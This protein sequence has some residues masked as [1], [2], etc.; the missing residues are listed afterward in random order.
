[1]TTVVTGAAGRIGR[2]LVRHLVQQGGSVRGIVRKEEDAALLPKGCECAV[3]DI[4]SDDLEKAFAGATRVVH[5]AAA[6]DSLLGEEKLLSINAGGTRRVLEAC[7]KGVSRVVVASS[8]S[9]YGHTLAHIPANEETP[10]HPDNAYGRSKAAVED[11][12]TEFAPKLPITILRF[13]V[14]YGPGF[15]AGY[16]AMLRKLDSG[17]M[18][19][20]G[21]G[22][23]HIPF[24]HVDDILDGIMAALDAKTESG[25]GYLLCGE[26]KTQ[27][28]IYRIACR[29][30]GVEPPQ[31]S[32]PPMLA[33]LAAHFAVFRDGQKAS[34]TPDM[35]VTICADREFDCSRA[36]AELGWKAKVKLEDGIKQMTKEYRRVY[37]DGKN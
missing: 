23:N 3:A 20:I 22:K 10:M 19:I 9:V 33:K 27:E 17:R 34:L 36:G 32:V 7:P 14:V 28:E 29:E 25:R 15:E 12:C 31:K 21:S 6:I 30:L 35:I 18:R 8:I 1:M 11:A 13:G 37:D 16:T 2:A 5:L 4:L 24:V 26:A